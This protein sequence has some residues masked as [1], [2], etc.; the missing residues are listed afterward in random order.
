[1]RR[2]LVAPLDWGLGHATRCMPVIRT[3]LKNDCEV[4]IASSGGALALLQ[5]EFP[6]IKY[7]E[8]PAY[9]PSYPMKGSMV[10]KMVLQLPHFVR[11]INK[12]HIVLEEIVKQNKV[13]IVISDNR[14]GCWSSKARSVFI[15]HQSN[16]MMPKRFGWLSGWVRHKNL[17]LIRKFNLCWIPDNPNQSLA[18]VLAS[19]NGNVSI[20]TE[21]IG[22]LSRFNIPIKRPVKYDVAVILSGPEPQRSLFEKIIMP[23]LAASDLKYFVVRGI[24]DTINRSDKHSCDFMSAR[25]LQELIE[26][27]AVI[28]AR[29]GYSTV[30][31]MAALKKKAIFVPTPGQTEQEYLAARLKDQKIAFSMAQPE[32]NL[33]FA[34]IE[35]KAYSGFARFELSNV[36]LDNAVQKLLNQ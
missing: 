4:L 14:Y 16:I 35:S 9:D 33:N 7:F 17:E 26:S 1:M 8:L 3:L 12:E 29:S 34:L 31:D 28:I 5:Q 13:D 2:V 19:F 15:T 10:W 24:L 23:Q 22:H 32:F 11:V 20:H 30:M 6:N 25:D 18:G 36:L 21:Y 27:S